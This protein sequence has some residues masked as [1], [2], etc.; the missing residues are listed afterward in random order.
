M[1]KLAMV[2]LSCFLLSACST[3]T[4]TEQTSSENTNVK[5]SQTASSEEMVSDS[6]QESTSESLEVV[7]EESKIESSSEISAES[8]TE[9]SEPVTQSEVG[10]GN[11]ACQEHTY[12]Y[13]AVDGSL[14]DFV[15]QDTV[16]AW[17]ESISGTDQYNRTNEDFSIVA[18]VNEFNI[19]KEDFIRVSRENITN[20]L[21]E[22]LG[23]TLDEYLAEYGYT[24]E[25]I[26]AIYSGDQAQIN[27]AFCG[28][29]AYY[30]PAD[31]EL[32]SI[33]WLSDHTAQEYA[34]V[35]LPE[36]EITRILDAA[37]TAGGGY[38]TLAQTAT[39][40]AQTYADIAE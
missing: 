31:G 25:Q 38:A 20:D 24:D 22:Q 13:H 5:V 39:T 7:S 9:E 1:K 21:L 26:D 14:I 23:L 4:V 32:Y 27:E 35:G 6:I 34:A 37:E 2:I 40:Q 12:S 30:N 18:F 10:G 19:L 11:N 36:A 15:G 17:Y 3:Q 16:N 8:S 28:D 33:Y 29:M